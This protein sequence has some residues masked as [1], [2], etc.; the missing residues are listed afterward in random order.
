M[1]LSLYSRL[2]LFQWQLTRVLL[3]WRITVVYGEK[4][5]NA[6]LVRMLIFKGIVQP[7]KRG[8]MGSINR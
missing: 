8:V 7:L 2:Y 4:I 3:I 1:R 5:W 6:F